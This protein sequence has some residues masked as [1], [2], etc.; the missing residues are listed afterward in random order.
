MIRAA[1]LALL[2][3]Q[4]ALA[5]PEVVLAVYDCE[6]GIQLRAAYVTAADGAVVVVHVND[7][8]FALARV[9]AA[10]GAKYV[11][12]SP[13]DDGSESIWW[14]KRET[15]LFGLRK[16]ATDVPIAFCQKSG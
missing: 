4:P 5:A 3:A 14:D 11:G 9:E 13:E 7:R 16:N 12:P 6:G 1:G 15:A 8:M 2:L 10:S